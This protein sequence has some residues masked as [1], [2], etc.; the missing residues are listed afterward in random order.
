MAAPILYNRQFPDLDWLKKQIR[1]GFENNEGKGWP[2]V[3]L[4]VKGNDIHRPDIKGPLSV[5]INLKGESYCKTGPYPILLDEDHYFISNAEQQY[6]LDIDKG[7]DTETFNIHFGEQMIEEVY[8]SQTGKHS[9]QLDNPK[10]VAQTEL[11]FFDRLHTQKPEMKAIVEQLK[12]VLPLGTGSHLYKQELLAAFASHLLQEHH[13]VYAMAEKLPPLKL[14]TRIELYKRLSLAH[15]YIHSYYKQEPDLE[16]IAVAACLSRFHF[17][18]LFKEIYGITPHQYITRL[19]INAAQRL[20]NSGN[21]SIEQIAELAGFE[22]SSSFCRAFQ[23]LIGY[24][25]QQYRLLCS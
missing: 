25:P 22:H 19:K 6:T 5:F 2:T 9:A 8:I 12:A 14:S 16:E 17:L 11:F 1:H 4:H 24:S 20:L 18:R 21:A 13:N 23:K 3:I 15:D 7:S 10:P